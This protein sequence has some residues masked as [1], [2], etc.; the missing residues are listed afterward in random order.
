MIC[1]HKEP[2]V[3]SL[4]RPKRSAARRCQ[5]RIHASTFAL[6][7]VGS[8]SGLLKVKVPTTSH[9]RGRSTA[10]QPSCRRPTTQDA[11]QESVGVPPHV[12]GQPLVG[13]G[14]RVAGGDQPARWVK[15]PP[16]APSAAPPAS[17]PHLPHLAPR[18]AGTWQHRHPRR[19]WR[20]RRIPPG[21]RSA[22][23][24]GPS[25]SSSSAPASA[26]A[27]SPAS[28]VCLGSSSAGSASV[29]AG[30]SG[31]LAWAPGTSGAV[32]TG[33]STDS[34]FGPRRGFGRRCAAHWCGVACL[35]R[36]GGF[37]AGHPRV[38]AEVTP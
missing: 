22:S 9:R 6:A 14:R 1:R 16:H 17:A 30:S 10:Y 3:D 21:S 24:V 23:E 32:S 13:C 28:A 18:T 20:S 34:G 4:A 35:L 36:S 29:A 12:T 26:S 25:S 37:L 15:T 27:A 2:G 19:S 7:R 8:C 38:W 11:S 5:A 33:P 31:S